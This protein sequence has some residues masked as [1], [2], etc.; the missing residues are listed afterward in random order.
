MN[1]KG[2]ELQK[3]CLE[4]RELMNEYILITSQCNKRYL[5]T[6]KNNRQYNFQYYKNQTIPPYRFHTNDFADCIT[7][8]TSSHAGSKANPFKADNLVLGFGA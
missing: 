3:F 2:K 8:I 4:E 5:K 6:M 1:I 7:G